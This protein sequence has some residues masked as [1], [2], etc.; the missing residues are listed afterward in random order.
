MA[1]SVVGEGEARGHF[2]GRITVAVVLTCIVAA[3]GGLI[4][5][6]DIGISGT[7]LLVLS[8]LQLP[9]R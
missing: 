7:L 4:F 8:S 3:S 2:S 5:G 1:G 6:Y 9:I